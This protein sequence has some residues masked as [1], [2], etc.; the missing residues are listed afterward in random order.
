MDKLFI[1]GL[2]AVFLTIA[3]NTAKK[4]NISLLSSHLDSSSMH[5]HGEYNS[6]LPEVIFELQQAVN[7]Q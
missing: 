2:D 6:S 3:L 7:S 4:F 5:I 1:K